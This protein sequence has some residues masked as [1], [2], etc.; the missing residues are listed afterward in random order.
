MVGDN[1]SILVLGAS[2]GLILGLKASF[3]GHKVTFVCR[4]REIDLINLGKAAVQ[5]PSKHN[6]QVIELRADTSP[7]R[8]RAIEPQIV[9]PDD[10]DFCILAMQEPQYSSA[11]V[12]EL[13]AKISEANVPV[14]S[15]T[16]MPLPPLFSGPLQLD[17]NEI[18]EVWHNAD[19]WSAVDS[20]RF[21]AASPDPQAMMVGDTQDLLLRVNHPTNIKAA[22]FA[23]ERAQEILQKLATSIDELRV[24]FNGEQHQ[25]GVR[26]IGHHHPL[27]SMAKWPMLITG[28]FRC[29]SSSGIVSIADAVHADPQISAEIY[30]WVS[31]LCQKLCAAADVRDVPL[32]P[33]ERYAE[34]AHSLTLP[35]SLARGLSNGVLRVERV[36]KLMQKLAMS[37]DMQNASLDSIVSQVDFALAENKSNLVG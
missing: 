25:I 37:F 12:I 26:L 32:V 19:M 27:V 9:D 6:A 28:N 24:F 4:P 10:Y 31:L 21:S 1:L 22:P 11:E 3:C 36:D 17:L 8:P 29:W 2:Y 5:I 35:S 14:L 16:N 13:I 30:E 23:N 7:E 33:F 15:I 20:T 34:A 18:S